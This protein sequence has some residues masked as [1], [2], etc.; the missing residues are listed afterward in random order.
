[1]ACAMSS[2]GIEASIPENEVSRVRSLESYAILG[3]DALT[4]S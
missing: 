4:L 2:T 3:T 1:M